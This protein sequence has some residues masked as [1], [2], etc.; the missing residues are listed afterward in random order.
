[1]NVKSLQLITDKN[2]VGRLPILLK[3]TLQCDNESGSQYRPAAFTCDLPTVHNT[4]TRLPPVAP[5]E[6]SLQL[7]RRLSPPQSPNRPDSP[8]SMGIL[9]PASSPPHLSPQSPH[10]TFKR[11]RCSPVRSESDLSASESDVDTS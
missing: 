2:M 11:R 6:T 5:P 4:T 1:M 3:D 9:S 7:M 8:S 10:R